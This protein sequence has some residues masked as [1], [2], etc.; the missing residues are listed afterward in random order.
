MPDPENEAGYTLRRIGR[1]RSPLTRLE[2]CPH[3]GEEG[4]A[5][6]WLELEPDYADGLAGIDAGCELLL[7]TWLH[8]GD[9]EVLQVHPRGDP[10]N[11]LRGVFAT[12][13]PDRPNPVGLHHVRVLAIENRRLKVTPLEALDGTPVIDIKP[14]RHGDEC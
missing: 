2:D 13:S 11:P 5:E 12:R 9:R 10:D 7:F 4:G 8:L 3:Q 6:A 14:L 1:V